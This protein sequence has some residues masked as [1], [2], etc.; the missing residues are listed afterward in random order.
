MNKLEIVSLIVITIALLIIAIKLLL[1]LKLISKRGVITQGTIF[2]I[3]QNFGINNSN[4]S[5]PIIRFVDDNNKWITKTNKLSTFP[6]A[7]KKGQEVT[8]IYEKNNSENFFI[9]D[10]FTYA[11]PIIMIIV[12]LTFGIFAFLKLYNF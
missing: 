7:Y 6:G 11:I 1:N 5:Y 4:I 2:D 12:S 8:V 9:K 3:E 10:K